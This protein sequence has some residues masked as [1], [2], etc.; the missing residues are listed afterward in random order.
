[1]GYDEKSPG[2]RG[3]PIDAKDPADPAGF[4]GEATQPSIDL[5]ELEDAELKRSNRSG[6]TVITRRRDVGLAT[7]KIESDVLGEIAEIEHEGDPGDGI[8]RLAQSLLDRAGRLL[9]R[10]RNGGFGAVR[11]RAAVTLRKLRGTKEYQAAS[12][13]KF[14]R[15]RAKQWESFNRGKTSS[16]YLQDLDS[17]RK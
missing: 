11:A 17:D 2:G 9:A 10:I 5:A 7:H 3:L 12:T 16:S 15:E 6:E 4:P 14:D 1:M 13:D 8:V